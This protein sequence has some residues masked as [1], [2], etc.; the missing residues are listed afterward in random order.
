MVFDAAHWQHQPA[1]ADLPGYGGVSAPIIFR[2]GL[3]ALLASTQ[4]RA[5][6][7]PTDLR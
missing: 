1:Q 2:Q 7:P 3:F 6:L 5:P 4:H